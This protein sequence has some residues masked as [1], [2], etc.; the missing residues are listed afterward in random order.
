MVGALSVAMV[1]V[2]TNVWY[3]CRRATTH[4]PHM[5]VRMCGT[6]VV[7]VPHIRMYMCGTKSNTMHIANGSFAHKTTSNFGNNLLSVGAK[8]ST[9]ATLSAPTI[10]YLE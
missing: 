7:D 2:H 10:A 6:C 9:I 4:L 1:H 8:K 5:Y 3:M